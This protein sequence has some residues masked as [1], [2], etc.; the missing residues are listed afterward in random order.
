MIIYLAYFQIYERDDVVNN[1]YNARIA[2][3]SE[4]VR[5]GTIYSDDMQELAYTATDDDGNETRVYPFGEIFAQIV[6]YTTHGKAGIEKLC[7]YDLLSSNSNA[8]EKIFHEFYGTKDIGDN[9]VTTLNVSLQQTAYDALGDNDGAVVVMEPSTGKILAMVSKPDFDPNEIDDIW[10]D[11]ISDDDN[12]SLLNRATQGLYT[13]GS[14]FKIFTTL[15]YMRENGNYSDFS[16]SCGG[17]VT[18][19]SGTI[20]C[21]NKTKHGSVNLESSFAYSCNGAFATIGSQLNLTDYSELCEDLLFNSKLPLDLEYNKSR[22]NL[23]EDSTLFDVTQTAIG[24]GTTLVTPI[25]MAM[26]VSAI[27]NDGVLMTPYV[28]DRIEN[29][30]GDVKE[31]NSPSKYGNLMSASEAAQLQQYMEAVTDYGTAKTLGTSS[32]YSAAGKTGTAQLDNDDNIN[33]WFVGYSTDRESTIAICVVIENVPQGSSSAT[34]IT[35]EI[36]DKYWE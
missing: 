24:Q 22:F 31:E 36:F 27:A 4:Y 14:I 23:T 2:S 8:L 30:S 20:N 3:Q 25:H 15:E 12:T 1:S 26:V 13:P 16:Y 18:F 35:K 11:I 19:S 9:V 34:Q 5:R 7:E 28:V 10:N 29:Y 17:S 32:K 21:F 6:G 33:S